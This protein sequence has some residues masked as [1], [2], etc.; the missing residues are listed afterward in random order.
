MFIITKEFSFC[1]AHQLNEL[2]DGHP[3]SRV[4]GHNYKVKVELKSNDLD[5]AGMVQDYGD[6]KP[7]KDWIDERLDHQ[8]LNDVVLGNPTAENIARWLYHELRPKYPLLSAV[9]VSETDKT[10]AR[11]EPE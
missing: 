5:S 11:Y 3:C 10:N 1:A 4:H 8:N 6:L 9:E 7:I 2:R